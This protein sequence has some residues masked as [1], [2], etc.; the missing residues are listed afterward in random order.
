MSRILVIDENVKNAERISLF[1]Q[2][3]GHEVHTD[4]NGQDG[5]KEVVG[6]VP[7]LLIT[8]I[9]LPGMDGFELIARVRDN[10]PDIKIIIMS[11]RVVINAFEY[12][13]VAKS[14]GIEFSI[15]KPF[16]DEYLRLIINRI[17]SSERHST[18]QTEQAGNW[19]RSGLKM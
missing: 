11:S 16:R 1:L 9:S 12:L 18:V 5:W 2:R 19:R 10:Y 17:I 13:K 3:E 14:F 15:L 8:E 4:Y 7:E 6:W